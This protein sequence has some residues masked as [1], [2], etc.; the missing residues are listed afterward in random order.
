MMKRD[1]VL[2]VIALLLAAGAAAPAAAQAEDGASYFTGHCQMC[3]TNAPGQRNGVGPNLFGVGNRKA[4]SAADFNYTAALKSSKLVWTQKTLD[5]FLAMP[6][7]MVPGTMM[8]ISVPD[9]AQRQRL[10]GY[11]MALKKK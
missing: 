6:P 3:H 10:I 8:V 9:A 5:K 1:S 11:L 2:T 7:A 4:G